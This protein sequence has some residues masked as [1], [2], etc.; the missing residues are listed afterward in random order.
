MKPRPKGKEERDGE[1]RRRTKLT[2]WKGSRM[3]I[4][5][6]LI[7]KRNKSWKIKELCRNLRRNRRR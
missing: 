5:E 1:S 2:I 3:G 7:L 6:E 4:E